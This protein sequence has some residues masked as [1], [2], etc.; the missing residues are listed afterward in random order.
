LGRSYVV[1]KQELARTL[2]FAVTKS[3]SVAESKLLTLL[4]GRRRN[5]K[6]HGIFHDDRSHVTRQSSTKKFDNGINNVSVSL[7]GCA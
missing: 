5:V 6:C 3:A 2:Q 7:Y 4:L 1:E